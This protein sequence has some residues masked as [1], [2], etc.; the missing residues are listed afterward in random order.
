MAFSADE[1]LKKAKQQTEES[2]RVADEEERERAEKNAQIAKGEL[3]SILNTMKDYLVRIPND[4]AYVSVTLPKVTQVL[5]N[6]KR[7]HETSAK[8]EKLDNYAEF[9]KSE[10]ELRNQIPILN[11]RQRKIE[12]K[13]ELT[14][15]TVIS[16]ILEV[17][18]ILLVLAGIFVSGE[19]LE[20]WIITGLCIVG[21]ILGLCIGGLWGAVGGFVVLGLLGLGVKAIIVTSLG[22]IILLVVWTAA[23]VA[24]FCFKRKKIIG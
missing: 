21:A 11:K 12:N 23:V 5:G 8:Y 13:S 6:A 16:I 20:T 18:V 17:I 22:R 2:K 19:K 4:K 7:I 1:I 3:D 10:E 15:V 14:K 9:L 24:F